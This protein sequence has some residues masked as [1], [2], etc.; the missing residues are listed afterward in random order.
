MWIQKIKKRSGNDE[1]DPVFPRKSR[2]WRKINEGI[3]TKQSYSE[4]SGKCN[5]LPCILV[6]LRWDVE[7]PY[8]I[9]SV[10]SL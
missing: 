8:V 7:W 2:T 3:F 9:L 4:V 5:Q 10:I 6:H 1:E